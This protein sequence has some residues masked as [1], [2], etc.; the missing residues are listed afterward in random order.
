MRMIA[1]RALLAAGLV[2]AT[3][4]VAAADDDAE[5]A[6]AL[7]NQAMQARTADDMARAEELLERSLE[8]EPSAPTAFN[9]AE[10]QMR[11]GHACAAADLYGALLG[12]D[13]GKLDPA[14]TREVGR[15]QRAALR[16]TARLS[17]RLDGAPSASL[18]VD[19]RDALEVSRGTPA[20]VCVD[21]GAHR[22]TAAAE[23]FATEEERFSVDAG[24]EHEVALT[25]RSIAAADVLSSDEVDE[26]DDGISPWWWVLAGVLV[27]G[28]A[29]GITVAVTAGGTDEV[30][31][32]VWGNKAA[33]H[34]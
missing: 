26:V 12:D 20:I 23:G 27:V 15:R 21:A 11:L 34:F 3:T 4:S 17:V 25:L 6:R 28:A 7:F 16:R 22:V 8:L 33:L 10:V 32:P 24:D 19:A 30:V 13:F 29:V 14:R 9:L 1:I 2:L 18:T 31:D 5:E